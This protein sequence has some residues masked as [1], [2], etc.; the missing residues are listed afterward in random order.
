MDN[1]AGL[2]C[3]W[4]IRHRSTRVTTDDCAAVATGVCATT[5]AGVR[6][7]SSVTGTPLTANASNTV[8]RTQSHFLP[9]D[10]MTAHETRSGRLLCLD[11]A[12]WRGEEIGLFLPILVWEG[13]ADVR[14]SAHTRARPP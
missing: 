10:L 11:D 4:S 5:A 7:P 2:V 1:A 12:S 14:L 6:D 9:P 8:H 13:C 3:G